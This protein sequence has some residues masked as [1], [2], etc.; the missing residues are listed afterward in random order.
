MAEPMINAAILLGDSNPTVDELKSIVKL[1]LSYDRF[2]GTPTKVSR[3]C[4]GLSHK[5][6]TSK[7][8][9]LY[10]VPPKVLGVVVVMGGMGQQCCFIFVR[11][12]IKL[13]LRPN[14]PLGPVHWRVGV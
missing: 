7:F 2:A 1:I 6:I 4:V 3:V 12:L 14:N 5:K 13:D 9:G 10:F 8:K 11:S